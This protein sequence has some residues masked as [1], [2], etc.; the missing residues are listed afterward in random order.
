VA[1]GNVAITAGSGTPIRVLTAL[2][3]GVADQQVVTLADSTGK[4]LGATATATQT[5][6]AASA[7]SVTVLA[8]NA[9]RLGATVANDST[10]AVL[11]LRLSATAATAASG[12][13]TAMLTAGAY[14]EV[15]FGYTGAIVGIWAAA[16][17]FANVSEMT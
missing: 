15:P 7:T 9:N 2:G 1:E 16:T 3:A 13:Y 5:G 8:S 12:G 14:Y 17:G 4:L 6:V 10:S 11:Y